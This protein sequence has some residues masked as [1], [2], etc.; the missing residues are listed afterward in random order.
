[1]P[2]RLQRSQDAERERSNV[3]H[4]QPFFDA[5][6]FASQFGTDDE[7]RDMLAGLVAAGFH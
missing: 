4:M 5:E 2:A 1:M 7:R 6:R 3:L